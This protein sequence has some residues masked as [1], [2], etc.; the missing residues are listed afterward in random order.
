MN[1][2]TREKNL[3]RLYIFIAAVIWSMGGFLIKN[4]DASPAFIALG[5]SAIAGVFLSPF[6]RF[7]KIKNIKKLI[8]LSLS[9]S[10]CLTTFVIST[11]L[12]A[13]ANA[14]AI[15]YSSPLFLFLGLW[16]YRKKLDTR[17]V[18]PMILILLGIISF[19]LEPVTGSNMSGNLLALVSGIAFAFVIYLFG[20]DYGI[21]GIGLTA[22]LN[23]LIVPFA[24]IVVPWKNVLYPTDL[25]SILCL[26]ILGIVQIG[27]SY[28]F[29]YEGRKKVTSLDAS[30]L[31]LIEPV[32]NPIWVFILLSEKPT[33]YAFFGMSLILL[34]QLLNT[35][36]EYRKAKSVKLSG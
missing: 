21:S 12:T 25:K 24:A 30:I 34:A 13:A 5:R 14:I 2:E 28:V 22:L 29:F 16:L 1:N 33:V 35:Y 26:A 10:T 8:F 9:Y 15:Q 7:K 17:K 20:F 19:L 32:L 6:I 18:V 31:T 3:G 27:I 23:I 36:L 11:K 4:I